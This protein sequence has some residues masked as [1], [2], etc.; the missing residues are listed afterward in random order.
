VCYLFQATDEFILIGSGGLFDILSNQQAIEFVRSYLRS[1]SS[2]SPA[3]SGGGGGG[4]SAPSSAM[5]S[6]VAPC[7]EALTLHA[8]D[9]RATQARRKK[10]KGGSGAAA[11][12]E[13]GEGDKNQ[14]D[15]DVS[16]VIVL[17]RGR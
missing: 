10:Q 15:R 2:A 13:T 5:F 8:M 3:H 17:L 12:E 7:V 1:H 14:K 6:Q 4:G 11:E 9:T 16:A